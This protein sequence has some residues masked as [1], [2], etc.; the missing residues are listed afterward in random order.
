MNSFLLRRRDRT[1]IR[2]ALKFLVASCVR[3]HQ[4]APVLAKS[5]MY[6]LATVRGTFQIGKEKLV[7]I[8]TSQTSFWAKAYTQSS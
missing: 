3:K 7:E 1:T 4:A 6:R 8:L 2:T 5:N